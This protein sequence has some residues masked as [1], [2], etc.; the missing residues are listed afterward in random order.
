MEMYYVKSENPVYE[1]GCDEVTD[2][3]K[4]KPTYFDTEER[5][6]P[7][8]L[9]AIDYAKDNSKNLTKARYVCVGKADTGFDGGLIAGPRIGEMIPM[10]FFENG[11]VFPNIGNMTI[12]D[13]DNDRW[14]NR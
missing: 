5:F 1:V 8:L 3:N 2:F 6:F 11:E 13:W 9:Y 7:S 14:D 4:I 12:K 10:M